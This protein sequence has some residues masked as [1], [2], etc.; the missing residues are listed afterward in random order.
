[1]SQTATNVILRR[2]PA[3]YASADDFDVVSVPMP[4]PADGEVLVRTHYLSL[5]PYMRGRMSDGP[6][7]ASPV[8][9]GSPM[10]GA[11][12]GEVIVS[13]SPSVP[14]GTTVAANG[15][16][17][18]HVVVSAN[19]VRIVD[20]SVAPVSTALGVLGMP[21]QT[22]WYGLNRIGHPKAGETVVVAAAT[23]AVGSV[24]GQ[25]ARIAGC[26][27]VGIAGSDE[28]C[29]H[30]VRDLGFD[31]CI[32]HRTHDATHL[33][34]ALREACPR[35]IDI[36]FENVGGAVLA[37][38][39]PNLNVGARIPL[40]GLI[41]RYNGEDQTPLNLGPLLANR[42]TLR[43]FIISDHPDAFPPFITE[44]APLVQAGQ[45]RYREDIVDGLENAP[46]AFLRLF[47]GENFGKLIV[48]VA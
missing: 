48:R 30:A 24:V 3:G 47:R 7:Y 20:P 23:G 5:D 27:V 12:V 45:V 14:I 10:V 46:T 19:A 42:V 21:G 13:R 33:R 6:S 4:E 41:S 17:R 36:Y 9:I 40:C 43:G 34:D 29:A 15:G 8:A 18:S 32:N 39:L 2:R 26:R 37:A 22:A 28:K 11:I 38:V 25:L 1:M 44:V 16:W 35:G 31:A